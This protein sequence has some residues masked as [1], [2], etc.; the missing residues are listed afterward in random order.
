[1]WRRIVTRSFPC[2]YWVAEKSDGVR[3]LLL[4]QTT[5]EDQGVYL[6]SSLNASEDDVAHVHFVLGRQIDRHN[7][8]YQQ[9]GLYFPHYEQLRMPLRNT[10]IDGELVVDIDP[11]TKQVCHFRC[12][13]HSTFADLGFFVSTPH[14]RK[15]YATWRSTAWLSMIEIS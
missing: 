4:V 10:L 12:S 9:D 8:Y 14:L 7:N 6:V 1:M 11:V 15:L 3:V 5:G 13:I 2:S